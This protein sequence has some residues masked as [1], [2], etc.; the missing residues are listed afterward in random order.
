MPWH[1]T[2]F[3]GVVAST[4]IRLFSERKPVIVKTVYRHWRIIGPLR[5]L[6]FR[7]RLTLS[8]RKTMR[9]PS[10]P[11]PTFFVLFIAAI[12]CPD[13]SAQYDGAT[14]VPQR[15]REGFR[16][17]TEKDSES[18]LTVLASSDL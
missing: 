12:C 5:Q 1:I 18:L 11:R 15:F 14:E 8:S 13:V 17:I 16:S 9:I 3:C 10:L 7:S 2:V 4:V 6:E